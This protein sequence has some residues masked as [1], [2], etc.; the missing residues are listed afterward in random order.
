MI[1]LKFIKSL[2]NKAFYVPLFNFIMN[3]LFLHF[4]FWTSPVEYK[5]MS[6]SL[7]FDIFNFMIYLNYI[8]QSGLRN[9]LWQ[10]VWLGN[11]DNIEFFLWLELRVRNR[12]HLIFEVLK[13]CRLLLIF[14]DWLFFFL[15]IDRRVDNFIVEYIYRNWLSDILKLILHLLLDKLFSFFVLVD[16]ILVL[17]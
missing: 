8:I 16:R 7:R 6:L 2:I 9:I 12:D 1:I 11:W 5:T 15:D 10:K 13:S 14:D 4:V 3:I 17:F